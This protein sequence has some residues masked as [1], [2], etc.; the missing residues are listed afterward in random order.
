MQIRHLKVRPVWAAS[1][2]L[3]FFGTDRYWYQKIGLWFGMWFIWLTFVSK[4]STFLPREGNMPLKE[5]TVTPKELFPRCIVVKW[6]KRAILNAVGLSGRG[7]EWLLHQFLWQKRTKDFF[8]S[9]MSVAPTIEGKCE[10]TGK[11]M[12]AIM[13][14][15][16]QFRARIGGQL[17]VSC[18]NVDL[19]TG[20]IV[21]DTHALLDTVHVHDPRKR[22]VFVVK[23][24]PTTSA[25]DIAEIARHERCDGLCIGNTVSFGELPEDIDWVGIFGTADPKKSPLIERGF[26]QPGG[27]SGKALC[28]I[29]CRRIREVRKLGVKIHI[30]GCGGI[31]GPISAF[32]VMW[33]G[34]D[35]I[36]VGSCGILAPWGVFP[37]IVTAH[38]YNFCRCVFRGIFS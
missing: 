26:A 9:I 17:N 11:C 4:T 2:V 32:R 7:L 27:Y 28:K 18:P 37:A 22:I 3:G 10:E 20:N 12:H 25:Y 16:D 31:L 15:L 33:A 21:T 23:V 38:V 24:A 13:N 36:S 5:G 6:W 1:G 8:I 30:N 35:S 29:I 19:K 14:R 34:A